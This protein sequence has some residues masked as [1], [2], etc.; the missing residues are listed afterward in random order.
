MTTCAIMLANMRWLVCYYG[1]IAMVTCHTG[2]TGE[3]YTT[4][5]S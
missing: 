2:W 1:D 3:V 5:M 4:T